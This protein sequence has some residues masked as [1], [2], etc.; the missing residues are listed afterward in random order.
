M[1]HRV[2]RT[3]VLL[4]MVVETIPAFHL[5][6][7]TDYRVSKRMNKIQKQPNRTNLFQFVRF[8]YLVLWL[9]AV[10]YTMYIVCVS[11]TRFL[12][13][14]TGRCTFFILLGISVTL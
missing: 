7:C 6:F 9:T 12:A 5:Y 14:E 10:A 11:V 1:T 2:Q 3:C 4:I 13:M 8:I